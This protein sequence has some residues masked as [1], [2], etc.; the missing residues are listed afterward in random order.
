MLEDYEVRGFKT[1]TESLIFMAEF[2]AIAPI[3]EK[4]SVEKS[5][6]GDCH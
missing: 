5:T 4:I 2:T 1:T 6:I 3:L